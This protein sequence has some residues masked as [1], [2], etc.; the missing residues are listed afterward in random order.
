MESARSVSW[1]APEHYHIPKGADWF[2]ALAIIT[3]ALV[4]AV[5]FFGNLLFAIYVG[6]VGEYWRWQLTCDQKSLLSRFQSGELELMK[7]CI[8][9]PVCG[10]GISMRTIHVGHNS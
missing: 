7:P 9:I 2:F 5:I 10:R 3:V 8:H 6:W 4:V 1:E